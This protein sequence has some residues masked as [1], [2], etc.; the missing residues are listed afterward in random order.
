MFRSI[1]I[2][3][4][5]WISAGVKDVLC[6]SCIERVKC[7]CLGES[8]KNMSQTPLKYLTIAGSN[9]EL[10]NQD[11]M[12]LHANSLQDLY[13]TDVRSLRQ[14]DVNTFEGFS[15]IRTLS[16]VN[17]PLLTLI[18][19][20]LLK[21][22][23][24][25]KMLKIVRTGITHI[26]QLP[27]NTDTIMEVIDLE[28][29]KINVVSSG[30]IRVKAEHLFLGYNNI[31]MIEGWAFNGSQIAKLNLRGNRELR[32]LSED[33]FSGIQD[34]QLIN[35]SDTAITHLPTQ[36]L[37]SIETLLIQNTFTLKTI[38]SIYEFKKLHT[39]HL[40][41]SFHCCA[42]QFPEKHDPHK[43]AQFQSFLKKMA[44]TCGNANT[45]DAVRHRAERH[46]T[47]ENNSMVDNIVIGRNKTNI[48]DDRE[49]SS[50]IPGTWNEDYMD[51]SSIVANNRIFVQCGNIHVKKQQL[52]TC[53]PAP[54]A[55][56][57][58]ED[59][60][61]YAW[62]RLCVWFVI[63]T[64]IV[65]NLAVLVVTLSHTS[66]K[67]VPRFLISH[68]ATADLCMAFYLLLL[69]IKDLQSTEYYFN[70]A[71]DWQKG[72]GCKV[73]GFVTIFASQLSIFTLGLITIER[74]YSIKR[75][76]YTNKLTIRRTT[77]FM[78]VGYAYSTLMALLPILGIS[79]YSS[80]S[81]CLPMN[82]Q[83]VPSLLYVHTLLLFTA[84]VF[85][86]I[87]VCYFQIYSSLDYKTRH[88]KGESKIA[89]KM[90]LLVLTNFVCWAPVSFFAFTAALGYPLISVT[91]SK[92]LLVFFYPI[93]SCF[94]PYLYALLTKHYRRDLVLTLARIGI[95]KER[96]H[97]YKMI[98][99][100]YTGNTGNHS[101]SSSRKQ[102][103]DEIKPRTMSIEK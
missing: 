17:A 56:N 3:L 27:V 81:I 35:L 73:A 60:M 76:L 30:S 58:C 70:H 57:P 59:I 32:V 25:L 6:C 67:S 55:F 72:Y 19:S 100:G 5:F 26:P 61:G 9:I 97:N 16:I 96:A 69:A 15:R 75:A 7:T 71:Y 31:Q 77:Y 29:N 42:F 22:L 82:T 94:N 33:A 83:D 78:L 48:G 18:S 89:R 68:L 51:T 85:C 49:E 86:M 54:D 10:L 23:S 65:G 24:T 44:E 43:H 99:S 47:N 52:I 40:T 46:E 93:N 62:L 39:A 87:C 1:T 98:L 45:N 66:E 79:S 103:H 13:L 21:Q 37:A 80:V 41:Y 95:C 34:L 63:S 11:M 88:N 8:Y 64:A 101:F 14:I 91:K 84:L 2:L 92:I 74:W 53:T 4:L 12:Q 38:P 102:S 28:G 50:T 36:G 90:A 20:N